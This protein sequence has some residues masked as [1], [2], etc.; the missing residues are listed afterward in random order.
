MVK[1]DRFLRLVASQPY[2][3][4]VHGSIRVGCCFPAS[5][6]VAGF[7][8]GD[9]IGHLSSAIFTF[10]RSPL[11]LKEGFSQAVGMFS[12][13]TDRLTVVMRERSS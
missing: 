2:H 10:R 3:V 4:A 7:P 13:R 9:D 8:G 1:D 6:I 5:Q 11:L 12:R